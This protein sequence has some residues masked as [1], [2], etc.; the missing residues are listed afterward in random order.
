MQT[1][2]CKSSSKSKKKNKKRQNKHNSIKTLAHK[3]NIG[4]CKY[5]W[6]QPHIYS[7]GD[8]LKFKC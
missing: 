3:E 1:E 7:E 2:V 5:A 8:T 4:Y 6:A